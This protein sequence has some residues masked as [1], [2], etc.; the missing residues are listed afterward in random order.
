MK[1]KLGLI[2]FGM[3]ISMSL[4]ACKGDDSASAPEPGSTERP[5][6]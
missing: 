5:R 1:K 3:I 4:A 6:R 2:V